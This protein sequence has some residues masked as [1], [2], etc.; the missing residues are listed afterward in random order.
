[1]QNIRKIWNNL[2]QGNTERHRNLIH[3]NTELYRPAPN[4]IEWIREIIKGITRSRRT[5]Y[6]VV[7]S[8]TEWHTS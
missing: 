4:Y 8:T 7:Q 5:I 6:E 1:M 2:V 3:N